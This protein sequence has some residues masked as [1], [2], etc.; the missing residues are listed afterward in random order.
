MNSKLKKT[1]A[2][3]LLSTLGFVSTS[4]I[5]PKPAHA[6]VG[7][8]VGSGP[9]VIAALVTGMVGVFA[10]PF[11]QD[12]VD[13]SFCGNSPDCGK[14]GDRTIQIGLALGILVLDGKNPGSA[15]LAP[16]NAAQAKRFGLTADEARAYNENLDELNAVADSV[17][18]RL[19]HAKQADLKTA[20][21][22]W[23]QYGVSVEPTA[24]AAAKKLVTNTVKSVR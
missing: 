18:F 13:T 22:L 9:M 20:R 6:I 5:Q 21:A 14:A 11:V 15:S 3:V 7:L 8:A 4:A 16:V 12:E 1:S 10:A 2:L 17:G 24:L 23:N 19:A